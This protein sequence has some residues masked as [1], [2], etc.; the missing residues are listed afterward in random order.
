MPL[1]KIEDDDNFTIKCSVLAGKDTEKL[2]SVASLIKREQQQRFVKKLFAGD[3]ASFDALLARLE[4]APDWITAHRLIEMH[5]KAHR[6]NPYQPEATH[7]S[8]LIYKRYFPRDEH[9]I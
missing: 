3:M 6:L 5:F 1:P 8:N 2:Q 4:I 7:F 9:I